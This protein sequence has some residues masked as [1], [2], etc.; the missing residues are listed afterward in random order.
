VNTL[1]ATAGSDS[2]G[3]QGAIAVIAIAVVTAIVAL[4]MFGALPWQNRKQK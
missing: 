4:G 2:L 3:W 1:A